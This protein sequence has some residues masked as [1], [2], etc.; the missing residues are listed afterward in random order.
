MGC[1]NSKIGIYWTVGNIDSNL[2][3]GSVGTM[4][5]NLGIARKGI[6]KP[7]LSSLEFLT[8]NSL[9]YNHNTQAKAQLLHLLLLVTTSTD[10]IVNGTQHLADD[11][12][13]Y[14]DFGL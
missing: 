6:S 9:S 10:A 2:V 5:G 13:R 7:G 3:V 4:Y 12:L 1:Q 8:L 14:R 11:E